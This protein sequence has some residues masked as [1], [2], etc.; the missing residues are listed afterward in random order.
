AR[1]VRVY[2]LFEFFKNIVAFMLNSFLKDTYFFGGYIWVLVLK[3]I[4]NKGKKNVGKVKKTFD[5][6]FFFQMLKYRNIQV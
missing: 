6:D 5:F 1:K 4:E 2:M 3:W